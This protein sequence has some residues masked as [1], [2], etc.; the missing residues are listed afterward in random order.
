MDYSFNGRERGNIQALSPPL[1]N[2]CKTRDKHRGSHLEPAQTGENFEI[3][4]N[5]KTNLLKVQAVFDL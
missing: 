2:P 3:G 5:S 1:S 4:I